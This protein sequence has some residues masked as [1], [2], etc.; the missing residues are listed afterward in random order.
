M[1]FSDLLRECKEWSKS[2]QVKILPYGMDWCHDLNIT[3]NYVIFSAL[4]QDEEVQELWKQ[5]I[6]MNQ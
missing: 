6:G 3:N 2:R 1:K 4:A 5:L